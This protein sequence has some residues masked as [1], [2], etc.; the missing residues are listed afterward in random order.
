MTTRIFFLAALVL[1]LSGCERI[2]ELANQSKLNG[3][4]IGAS[5]RNT[6]RS[7]ED[8][9][10]R[11]PRVSKADIYAGWKEMNEYM[12]KNKLEVIA[13]L[14]DPPNKGAAVSSVEIGGGTEAA[15]EENPA[16]AKSAA[17]TEKNASPT[18]H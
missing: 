3:R 12:T 18:G 2:T 15:A 10:Q 11:N 13:P 6:G 16:D 17:E 7:L 8:C 14:P 4:A 1:G 5:C 9:F